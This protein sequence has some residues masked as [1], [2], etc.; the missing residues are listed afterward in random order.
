ME[1][2]Q[3]DQEQR[4]RTWTERTLWQRR[5]FL[6]VEGALCKMHT[7]GHRSGIRRLTG[8][9]VMLWTCR[10]TERRGGLGPGSVV[11]QLLC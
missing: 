10:E 3:W 2:G 6:A 8:G 5:G 11:T 4:Q 1:R 9:S 7:E